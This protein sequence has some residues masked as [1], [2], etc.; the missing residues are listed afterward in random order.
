MQT[1]VSTMKSL[2]YHL[3]NNKDVE[4]T[5]RINITEK[6]KERHEKFLLCLQDTKVQI[7]HQRDEW[8]FGKIK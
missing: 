2:E 7:P 5:E 8:Q 3:G 4:P 1:L 6:Q